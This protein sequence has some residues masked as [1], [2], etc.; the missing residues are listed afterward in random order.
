MFSISKELGITAKEPRVLSLATK[1]PFLEMV[2]EKLHEI[3]E[4][5]YK[6]AQQVN[7]VNFPDRQS[8][9]IEVFKINL[10]SILNLPTN[11]IQIDLAN[12]EK[13]GGADL[14]VTFPHLIKC[15]RSKH[16]TQELPEFVRKI[17]ESELANSGI[18][19]SVTQARGIYV[20]LTLSLKTL[21]G[22]VFQA[23]TDKSYGLSNSLL[24]RKIVVDYSSP[25]VAKKLHAGHIRSTIIGHILS[26]V[27][28]SQAA[29]VFRVN[30]INDWG[31]FGFF[32]F[33]DNNLG[34]RHF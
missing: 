34:R 2:K 21:L 29:S 9:F 13:T 17:K 26:N 12:R 33:A 3:Q 20:N 28:E 6:K 7:S 30:H 18:V 1:D 24:D 14:A 11:E 8:Y 32:I 10:S 31:G 4:L 25:N 22:S 19:A 23:A 27:Y 15:D 5:C 16:I